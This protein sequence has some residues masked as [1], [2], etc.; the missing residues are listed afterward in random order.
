MTTLPSVLMYADVIML[1]YIL[2]IVTNVFATLNGVY[3]VPR[4]EPVD[5]RLHVISP[6]ELANSLTV[7]ASVDT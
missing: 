7:G 4:Y 3:G 5:V 6:I 1:S 2:P